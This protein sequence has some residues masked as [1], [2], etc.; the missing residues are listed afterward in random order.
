[1]WLALCEATRSRQTACYRSF[2]GGREGW[3]GCEQA[4]SRGVKE[5]VCTCVCVLAYVRACGVCTCVC[6][7]ACV[8]MCVCRGV[9]ARVCSWM[10]GIEHVWLVFDCNLVNDRGACS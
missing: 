8:C 6:V 9:F 4:W 5:H 2:W 1:M 10:A 7:C 3:E